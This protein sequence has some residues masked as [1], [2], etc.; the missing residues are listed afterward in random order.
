MGWGDCGIDS[1]GRPIGYIFE[2]T[3]DHVDCYSEINRGLSYACGGMH[4]ENGYDCEKYFCTKH[5]KSIE[6]LEDKECLQLCEECY[7]TYVL[8]LCE[9]YINLMDDLL[10]GTSSDDGEVCRYCGEY[11]IWKKTSMCNI[12]PGEP[13]HKDN[14][15]WKNIK[16]LHEFIR[17]NYI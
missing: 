11:V 14:C 5:L 13:N 2:A 6:I 17:N 16:D 1:R 15:L 10:Y 3:C 8:Y 12:I 4:G 9:K 7:N